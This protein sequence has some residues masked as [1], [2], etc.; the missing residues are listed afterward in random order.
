ME[1]FN[2]SFI[3]KAEIKKEN[4]KYYV[5]SGWM[6][7]NGYISYSTNMGQNGQYFVFANWS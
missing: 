7:I 6:P 3:L 4:E 2:D 5:Y 1:C